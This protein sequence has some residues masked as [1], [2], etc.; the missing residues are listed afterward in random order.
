MENE[1]LDKVEDNAVVR[2]WSEKTQLGKGDSLAKGY[3]SKLCAYIRISV[4]QNNLHEL[5]EIWDQ[6]D[7]ETKQLFYGNYGY[8]SYLLDIK[9][10]VEKAYSRATYVPAFLK[11]LMNVMGMS[12]QWIAVRVKQ[13][14]MALGYVNEAVSDLFDRLDKGVTPE[15]DIEWKAPW[16]VPDKILFRCGSFD[17]VPLLG[18]WGSVRYAPLLV[19]RQYRSSQFILAMHGLA[20]FEF[21]YGG[22]NY[23]KKIKEISNA[24]NQTHRMKRV[25]VGPMTT[26]EYDGWWG[27]RIN[28]NIHRPRQEGTRPVEEYL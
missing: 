2:I 10:Q 3:T 24:W 6:W 22:V 9:I 27:R 5:K 25:A 15:E 14:G 23:K 26:L 4:T 16:L 7:D 11:K 13:R 19:L 12:E 21:T 28:D 18:I 20:Q 8:L 17:W 1:F